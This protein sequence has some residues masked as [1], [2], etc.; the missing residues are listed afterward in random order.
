VPVETNREANKEV[1]M[2]TTVK[3]KMKMDMMF[4]IRIPPSAQE[5]KRHVFSPRQWRH[6]LP[7]ISSG[8]RWIVHPVLT[9]GS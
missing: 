5:E 2:K 9:S 6:W 4:I 3:M 8:P 7:L 1:E